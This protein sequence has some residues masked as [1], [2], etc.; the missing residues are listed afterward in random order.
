MLQSTL[1]SEVSHIAAGFE[2]CL[3]IEDGRLYSWGKNSQGQLGYEG[4]SLFPKKVEIE[5][6]AEIKELWAEGYNSACLIEN[7]G[8]FYTW[9]EFSETQIPTQLELACDQTELDDH[10]NLKLIFNPDVS[11]LVTSKEISVT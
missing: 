8:L 9:G 3:M 4:E 11:F 7:F 1:L 6:M 10:Q 5:T 2:H